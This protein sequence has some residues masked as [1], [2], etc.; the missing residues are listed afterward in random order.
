[1]SIALSAV[2][3]L[4][5]VPVSAKAAQQVQI[6]INQVDFSRFPE[7]RAF[8]AVVDAERR[9][10]A[11]L[12]ASAFQL[13]HDGVRLSTFRLE[14]LRTSREPIALVLAIDRSGSMR[15]EPIRQALAAAEALIRGLDDKDLIGLVG[16]DDKVAVLAAPTRQHA[17]V[18]EH[19]RTATLGRDTAIN[20]AVLE[21]LNQVTPV[22][23]RRK[24]V[25]LLTDGKENRSKAAL[26]AVIEAASRALVPIHTVGL[27][28]SVD[29]RALRRMS[30]GTGGMA[31][32]SKRP[33][34]LVGLF[35]QI[36]GFLKN[37]Y[38][39]T[40]ATRGGEDVWHE[41][42]VAVAVAGAA[43]EARLPYRVA[44]ESGGGSGLSRSARASRAQSRLVIGIAVG[45]IVAGMVGSTI[46]VVIWRRRQI[47][48]SRRY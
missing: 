45:I 30:D 35:E 7:V 26:D 42:S 40:F 16:F 44:T 13:Q 32:E 29:R 8:V 36:G 5:P 12:P 4:A 38:V 2:V 3:V 37:E 41:I 21:A 43:A 22:Q 14:S 23:L 15:G 10:I 6:A 27:G 33:A 20:D 1:M 46:T 31:L 18:V 39:M 9:P 28:P 47:R 48:G 11:G 34:D 25:L 19:L 17:T 24:A